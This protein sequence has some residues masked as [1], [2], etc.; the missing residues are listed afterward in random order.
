MK[1]LIFLIIVFIA[2]NLAYTTGTKKWYSEHYGTDAIV[3]E[4]WPIFEEDGTVSNLAFKTDYASSGWFIYIIK[5][6]MQLAITLSM[7]SDALTTGEPIDFEF[8]LDST[9]Y[10]TQIKLK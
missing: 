3:T 8:I 1:N 9:Y 10:V 7:L 5:N 6:D 2:V 4:V